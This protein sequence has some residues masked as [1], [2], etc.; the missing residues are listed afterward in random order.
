[1]SISNA[2]MP[3]GMIGTAM[4]QSNALADRD[5]VNT[6][7]GMRGW[8]M[9]PNGFGY[10]QRICPSAFVKDA[11]QAL[12]H[13]LDVVLYLERLFEVPLLPKDREEL[14]EFLADAL[15]TA[16][17]VAAESYAKIRY[18]ATAYNVESSEYQL[19]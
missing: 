9:A 5:E 12:E 13:T 19:G 11:G 10:F 1:M 6:R 8:Q 2:T 4:A 16:D 15:G 7:L 17:I 14:A 3:T 18:V